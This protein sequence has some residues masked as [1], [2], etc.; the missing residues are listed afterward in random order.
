MGQTLTTYHAGPAI[1]GFRGVNFFSTAGY[2]IDWLIESFPIVVDA[3]QQID[4]RVRRQPV[5]L[6]FTPAGFWK[7]A[8]LAILYYLGSQ[9]FGDLVT[10]VRTLGT[11]VANVCNIPGHGLLSGDAVII[12]AAG[13]TVPTGLSAG[14][15][16]YVYA[17]SSDAV[18]FMAT[19]ANAVLGVSPLTIS[20]GSGSKLVV[21]NPL[22]V[23]SKDG[24]LYTF[25]NAAITK[26]PNI[27]V[28]STGMLLGAVTLDFFIKD[29]A[30]LSDTNSLY[31]LAANPWP[32]DGGITPSQIITAAPTIT[33]GATP[34]WNSFNT[35]NGIQVEFAETFDDI[36]VDG[37][38]T[39]SKRYTGLVV[40]GRFQ[41]V[42]PNTGDLPIALLLQG[43]GASIGRSLSAAGNNLVVS[44]ATQLNIVLNNAALRGGPEQYMVRGDRIG[45]LT[46]VATR[47]FTNGVPNP[48]FSVN[49]S[50]NVS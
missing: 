49:A 36:E 18:E 19:R 37:L 14:T 38:A 47:T 24:S 9:S 50:P 26:M 6:R 34:P 3:Y 32:G 44:I 22:T 16:Y 21:N 20:G 35:K 40:T 43:A 10:P 41:P 23:Q 45:E 12:N 28:H 46:V 13:G 25:P 1:I 15:T 30:N 31:T 29:N 11:I 42:G 27:T 7:A 8:D 33:W 17:I 5:R 48:L 2:S 4:E 39:I